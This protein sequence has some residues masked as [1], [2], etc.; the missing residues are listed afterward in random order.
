[1]SDNLLQALKQADLAN[2]AARNALLAAG[3]EAANRA[4]STHQA[5]IAAIFSELRRA[6]ANVLPASPPCT[7]R[8]TPPCARSRA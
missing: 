4:Y 5:F 6:C 2:N 3:I 1:M 8:G 7:R